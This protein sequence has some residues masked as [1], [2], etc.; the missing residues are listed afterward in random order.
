M[1]DVLAIPTPGMT[2]LERSIIIVL[3]IKLSS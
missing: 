3:A 1:G 2:M